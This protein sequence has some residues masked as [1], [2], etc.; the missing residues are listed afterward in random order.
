M[1]YQAMKS[2]KTVPLSQGGAD[3]FCP[4]RAEVIFFLPDSS[5]RRDRHERF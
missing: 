1:F 5:K 3:D 2:A 4:L